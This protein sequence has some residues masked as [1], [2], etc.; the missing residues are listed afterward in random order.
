MNPIDSLVSPRSAL[1]NQDTITSSLDALVEKQRYSEALQYLSQFDAVLTPDILLG[2]AKACYGLGN[3]TTM[4]SVISIVEY[5][6]W[7]TYEFY[8]LK[9]KALFSLK[10]Y[11]S[12]YE[13]FE[14][15]YKM[16][17][18]Q[19]AQEALFRCQ[20]KLFREQN[21]TENVTVLHP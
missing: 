9:G 7:D 1:G 16:H 11:E 20:I 17:P 6:E 14:K 10:E 15:S 2:K 18:T 19:E 12:S 5:I 13:A 3:Y 4:L 8:L 21:P